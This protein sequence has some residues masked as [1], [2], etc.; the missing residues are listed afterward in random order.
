[1]KLTAVICSHN[2]REDHLRR[3]LD[4]LRDQTLPKNEWEMILIDNAS[5]SPLAAL[6][7]LSWHPNARHIM[8]PEL[9][10]AAARIRGMKESC[11][12]LLVF[13]DDDNVID[14]SYLKQALEINEEW[15]TLG[16][17]GSSAIIPEYEVEPAGDLKNLEYMLAIRETVKARWS[18]VYSC[19]EAI[20]WGAG[21]CVRASVADAFCRANSET[22]VLITGQRGGDRS[23]AGE[24]N[25][26][27]YVACE[28]GLGMGVFPQLKLT[29][30]IAKERVSR[31][32]LLKL[33]AGAKAADALLQ[34]KW[35][36]RFPRSPF[37]PWGI[38]SIFTHLIVLRGL[39]RQTYLAHVRGILTARRIIADAR[40]KHNRSTRSEIKDC[41]PTFRA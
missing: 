8:E 35:Q 34:Y 1:M 10:I 21:L 38:L 17:W 11:S 19:R 29:H 30:L 14:K 26:I 39:E 5:Q 7:D 6:W 28:L 25:E 15:P 33:V 3:A 4:S 16:V 36:G 31:E 9:G 32:Y 2:P 40:A 37:R 20:P 27:V 18:N 12:D 24:D 41:T 23:V 13:V 22:P